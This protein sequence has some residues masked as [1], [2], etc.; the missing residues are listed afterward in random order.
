VLYAMDVFLPVLNLHQE[1]NCSIR[2][3]ERGCAGGKQA[4]QWLD[5]SLHR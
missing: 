1:E 2:P 4:M 3:E 5:G